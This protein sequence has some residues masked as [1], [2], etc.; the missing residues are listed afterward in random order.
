[1]ELKIVPF[2]QQNFQAV[3]SDFLASFNLRAYCKMLAN[4]CKCKKKF[5]AWRINFPGRSLYLEVNCLLGVI[6]SD[7][8]GDVIVVF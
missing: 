2:S 1:M 7:I 3:G 4:V 8:N 5:V 6:P